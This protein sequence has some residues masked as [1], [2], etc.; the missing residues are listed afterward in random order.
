MGL[1]YLTETKLRQA[2]HTLAEFYPI[3][4]KLQAA[5]EK[6]VHRKEMFISGSVAEV[7]IQAL[8]DK[9]VSRLLTA[10]TDAVATLSEVECHV[11]SISFSKDFISVN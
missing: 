7:Q 4:L 2:K 6:C 1:L 11:S 8:L 10:Q 5:E 9:A 3:Y